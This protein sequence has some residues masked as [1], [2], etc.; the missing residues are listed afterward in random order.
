[1]L[2]IKDKTEGLREN[3]SAEK[4][5]TYQSAGKYSAGGR[6]KRTYLG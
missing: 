6:V 1:M 4:T 5:K 3:D 2:I